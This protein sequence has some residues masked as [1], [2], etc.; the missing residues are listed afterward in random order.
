MTNKYLAFDGAGI[1]GVMVHPRQTM[2]KTPLKALCSTHSSGGDQA[3]SF[4]YVI[5]LSPLDPVRK[6]SLNSRKQCPQLTVNDTELCFTSQ[7]YLVWRGVYLTK[8]YSWVNMILNPSTSAGVTLL[9]LLPKR[10]SPPARPTARLLARLPAV[11]SCV[12]SCRLR[13]VLVWQCSSSSACCSAGTF[14]AFELRL[15]DMA[16]F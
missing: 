12:L 8:Q 7:G 6:R 5:R 9:L 15:T 13:R 4:G 2:L 16:R 1:S 11:V 10:P 14:P 3:E